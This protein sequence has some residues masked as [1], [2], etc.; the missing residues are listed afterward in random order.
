MYL[1]RV[2]LTN[3]QCFGPDP[4]T[5][6]FDEQLTALL[7]VNASGKTAALQAVLR[8]FS[9]VADQ[10]EIRVEDFHV[11]HDE[12]EPAAVRTLR[13]DAVFAFP[14][15]DADTTVDAGDGNAGEDQAD[16]AATVPEFFA[17]MA[18][19]SEGQLK[20]RIVLDATWTADGSASGLIEEQR[21][22]AYTFDDD[23]EDQC[24]DLR[25]SDRSRIQAVYVPATRDGGRQV[26]SFLRG[27]LWRASMW[28]EGFRDHIADAADELSVNFKTEAVVATVT[29]A[30]ASRWHELHHLST[31]QN[32]TFE[33]I[34]RDMTVLVSNAEMLFEPTATGRTR[35]AQELSDGQQSLLHIALTAATLDLESEIASGKHDDKFD[36]TATTLPT[37]TL[38]AIEEPENNLSPYF[39]SRVVEQL[40]DVTGS[41][42]AQALISSHSA[43]VV[44]RIPPDRVRHFRIDGTSKSTAVS[45]I[46]LPDD[47]TDA[48]KYMREAVQAHPELYF[49]RFVVLGE[50]ASEELVIPKLAAARDLHI[51]QSF[52]AVV[53]LGGRHTNHF[54]RLLNQLGIPHATLLDLDYGR[55]GGGEG[56]IRD[57]CNRLLELG[58][59]PFDGTEGVSDFTGVD[60]IEALSRGQLEAWLN[61]L[62]KWDVYFST[63]LDLDLLLLYRYE[64]A[65]TSH[66]ED[67]KTGPRSTG[68][69]RDSVLGDPQDRPEVD[70]YDN[71]TWTNF[72]RWYRYLFLSNSKPGTHLRAMSHVSKEELAKL[73]PRLSRLM[74]R[75]EKAVAPS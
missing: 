69:P 41:G 61:H 13:V 6:T 64:D 59:S 46:V 32:P 51:D 42:R 23:F 16:A 57:V 9:V 54:W 25:A 17:Q 21:R 63:P 14:E 43:S 65:Y 70:F 73:P 45:R 29:D 74:D 18:A 20:L 62:E 2:T 50:G 72:L 66:L 56:R 39:L 7:G 37:L 36:I 75:I 40:V 33:P 53:P 4:H 26:N 52:V 67:G 27:R 44:S 3:F 47:A 5:I 48:G 24:V 30:I 15:L 58:N 12:T 10:R 71:A 22:I 38:L 19:D 1:E 8:L 55:A 68:D 34:T 31:E 11:P 28:S 60:D 35:R 49:A